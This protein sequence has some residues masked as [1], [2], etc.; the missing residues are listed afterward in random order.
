MTAGEISIAPAFSWVILALI[1]GLVG[2]VVWRN[3][4]NKSKGK[5]WAIIGLIAVAGI[6]IL[7]AAQYTYSYAFTNYGYIGSL[8]WGTSPMIAA[9]QKERDYAYDRCVRDQNNFDGTLCD[10][11]KYGEVPIPP[12]YIL[13]L[14][15]SDDEILNE[16]RKLPEVRAFNEKYTPFEVIWR[17]GT[18]AYVKYL[19]ER[20][21]SGGPDSPIKES[22]AL[23]LLIKF[24]SFVELV[25]NINVAGK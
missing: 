19:V 6:V 18:S 17:E 3:R 9:E 23:H 21:R 10:R 4:K 11:I 14:T 16:A 20:L 1:V 5:T 15:M 25:L 8:D 7:F 12:K 22:E 13:S 2:L 24:D